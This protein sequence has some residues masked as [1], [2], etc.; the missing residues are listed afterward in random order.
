M[1]IKIVAL[2]CACSVVTLSGCASAGHSAHEQMIAS[3]ASDPSKTATYPAA[4]S[5]YLE[6]VTPISAG[7]MSVANEQGQQSATSLLGLRMEQNVTGEQ[8]DALIG[9]LGDGMAAT[10][11][12]DF[13]C[14]AKALHHM[15]VG[16]DD[17]EVDVPLFPL[18][19]GQAFTT[20]PEFCNGGPLDWVFI[21]SDATRRIGWTVEAPRTIHVYR[22]AG[23]E[24]EGVAG[25]AVAPYIR[26]DGF[27]IGPYGLFLVRGQH[28]LT[29]PVAA[30]DTSKGPDISKS[31]WSVGWFNNPR[32]E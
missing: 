10:Y 16:I 19:N 12:F 25:F 31:R 30:Y 1:K 11:F 15:V 5:E 32:F 2:M 6:S 4:Y 29:L 14:K 20:N 8:M 28:T 21:S 18:S 27:A 9:A 7:M 26:K 22:N 3:M 23:F 24:H 13:G 17:R